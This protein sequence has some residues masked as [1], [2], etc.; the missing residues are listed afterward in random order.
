MDELSGQ[1][2]YK[3]QIYR[4]RIDTRIKDIFLNK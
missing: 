3:R 2:F 1:K 4:N